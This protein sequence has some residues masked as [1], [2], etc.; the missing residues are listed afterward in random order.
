MQVVR[1]HPLR[2]DKTGFFKQDG[3]EYYLFRVQDKGKTYMMIGSENG[4]VERIDFWNWNEQVVKSVDPAML[5][6]KRFWTELSCSTRPKILGT[7]T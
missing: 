7:I 5:E 3:N 1:L 4:G 6:E 2:V